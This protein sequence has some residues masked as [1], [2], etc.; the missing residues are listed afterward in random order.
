M[1]HWLAKKDVK[2]FRDFYR[3]FASGSTIASPGGDFT[4]TV[5]QVLS[6]RFDVDPGAVAAM[7]TPTVALFEANTEV[8]HHLRHHAH[9]FLELIVYN[10][11]GATEDITVTAG[12]GFTVK[13]NAVIPDGACAIL[14]FCRDSSSAWSVYV[15]Q[16]N[17]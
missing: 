11:G 16:G 1:V 15:I 2:K 5:A 3:S 8:V 4:L 14:R 7:T 6:G 12:T 9:V 13:G 10:S 17:A